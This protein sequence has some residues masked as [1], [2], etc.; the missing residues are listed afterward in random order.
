MPSEPN[1]P[2]KVTLHYD[3]TRQGVWIGFGR[4]LNPS[5]GQSEWIGVTGTADSVDCIKCRITLE[6]LA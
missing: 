4:D 5:C 3:S 6:A 1:N 2:Y